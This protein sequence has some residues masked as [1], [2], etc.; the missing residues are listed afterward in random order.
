MDAKIGGNITNHAVIERF[1]SYVR[2]IRAS[3]DGSRANDRVRDPAPPSPART[4]QVT[5][6]IGVPE[7]TPLDFQVE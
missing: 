6:Q 4:E 1:C 7:G 2:A 5:N 3:Y